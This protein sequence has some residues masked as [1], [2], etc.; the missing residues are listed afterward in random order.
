VEPGVTVG[1]HRKEGILAFYWSSEAPSPQDKAAAVAELIV[2]LSII[3]ED[4]DLPEH[5]KG[6]VRA[7]HLEARRLL[8]AESQAAIGAAT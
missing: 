5:V 1:F 3:A 6:S 8:I 2:A 4:G 7:R